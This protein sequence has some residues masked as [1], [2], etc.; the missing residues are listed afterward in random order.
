MIMYDGLE[1]ITEEAVVT[2]S[3]VLSRISPGR[4]RKYMR[5]RSGKPK[6]IQN[7]LPQKLISEAWLI[8]SVKPA[9]YP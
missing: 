3:K 6:L 9:D 8:Y 5:T 2:Y 1:R 7:T 4:M